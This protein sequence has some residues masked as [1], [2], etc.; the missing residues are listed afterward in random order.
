M[1][2]FNLHPFGRNPAGL[3]EST[4]ERIYDSQRQ[5]HTGHFLESAANL[6]PIERPIPQARK[7]GEI[8]TALADLGLPHLHPDAPSIAP[9]IA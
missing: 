4:Q 3:P 6:R 9:P 8:E 5:A 2:R 7:Y 1:P